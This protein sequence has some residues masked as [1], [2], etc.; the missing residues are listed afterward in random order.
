MSTEDVTLDFTDDGIAEI[1]KISADVN[2]S[3]E[4]IGARR[5]HTVMERLL[6]DLL[7]YSRAANKAY[8]V[9]RIQAYG[10]VSNIVDTLHIPENL[11]VQIDENLTGMDVARMPIEQVFHNLISNAV[12]HHDKEDGSIKI[13]GRQVDDHFE[14]SIADDGPGISPDYHER[15]FE[16]FQTLRRRDEVEAS[17]I[18]LAVVKKIIHRYGGTIRVESKPGQ[19]SKFIFTWKQTLEMPRQAA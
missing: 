7:Q 8:P 15:I 14:F 13:S 18:G 2:G 5:L 9:E 17:G 4:N 6:D 10:L 11:N 3:V 19:G 1:A 12:K 16:M